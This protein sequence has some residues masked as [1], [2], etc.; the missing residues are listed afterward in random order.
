MLNAICN[1]YA[2]SRWEFNEVVAVVQYEGNCNGNYAAGIAAEII[3]YAFP[4]TASVVAI[5]YLNGTVVHPCWVG[6]P[7]VLTYW[8][9]PENLDG[10]DYR[11]C[12][13]RRRTLFK[14][15]NESYEAAIMP[16]IRALFDKLRR[17]VPML[18][19]GK[20]KNQ[21]YIL[22]SIKVI[23]N[24]SIDEQDQMN[25]HCRGNDRDNPIFNIIGLWA[26]YWSC[27]EK[28]FGL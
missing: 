2:S 3:T 13:L 4:P 5:E 14:M 26:L 1:Q 22:S 17:S 28:A 16:D 9:A 24:G 11:W 6:E 7:E 10:T 19:N 15:F 23:I 12:Y 27:Y 21:L 8:Y 18:N 25:L 20:F